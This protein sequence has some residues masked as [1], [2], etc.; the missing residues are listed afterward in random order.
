MLKAPA[1][2]NCAAEHIQTDMGTSDAGKLPDS[3]HK[4]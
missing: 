4:S 3:D 2:V 1:I